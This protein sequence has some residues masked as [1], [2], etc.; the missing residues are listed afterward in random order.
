MVYQDLYMKAAL[1]YF[2]GFL[3]FWLC[4]WKITSYLPWRPLRWWITWI[5][6]CVVLTPWQGTDP[7]IYY[8]PA[9]IVAAFDFLDLGM[10]EA[11]EILR[12]MGAAMVFGSLVIVLLAIILKIRQLKQND[13]PQT[14]Q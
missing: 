3:G 7:D 14:D 5:Y 2:A 10:A 6:F 12:P 13:Q 1:F 4:I 9:I 11:L 8:A